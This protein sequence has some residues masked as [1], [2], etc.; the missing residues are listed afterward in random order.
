MNGPVESGMGFVRV[1]LFETG[2]DLSED[3]VRFSDR[4]VLVLFS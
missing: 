4:P 1:N 2:W 3:D